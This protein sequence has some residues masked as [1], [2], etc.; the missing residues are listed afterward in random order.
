MP[1]EPLHR[2]YY[3]AEGPI[4]CRCK[5]CPI[6]FQHDSEFYPRVHS[7]VEDKTKSPDVEKETE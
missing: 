6:K 2:C 1:D 4:V 7:C 3:P 5:G